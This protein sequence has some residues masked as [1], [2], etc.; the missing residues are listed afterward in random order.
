MPARQSILGHAASAAERK[1]GLGRETN[2]KTLPRP[3]I[4]EMLS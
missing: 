4:K 2:L 3:N 1:A